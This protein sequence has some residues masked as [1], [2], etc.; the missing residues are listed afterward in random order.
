MTWLK[1]NWIK[2]GIGILILGVLIF[3]KVLDDDSS[4]ISE[5][6]QKFINLE[7]S[8][9]RF[10]DYQARV[11]PIPPEPKLNHE[12]N[13]YGMLFWTLTENWVNTASSYNMGGHYLMNRYATG[14]PD[15]LIIDGLTGQV[16]HEY[17]S[18]F[19]DSVAGSSLV[20]FNPIKFDYF[21]SVGD[22]RPHYDENP[23]YAVWDGKQF[24]TICEPIIKNWKVVSCS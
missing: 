24:N 14:N 11:Y 3:V 23:R 17:G 2:I 1:Q 4:V 13:S 6:E 21:S 7:K 9:P 22:Y 5:N 20:M 16:F 18:Q 10:E 8:L 19:P 15:V 12:S